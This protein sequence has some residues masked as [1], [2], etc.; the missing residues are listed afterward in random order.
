MGLDFRM[1]DF[2]YPLALLRMK[3]Q[4]ERNQYQPLPALQ[5]YQRSRMRKVLSHAYENV[6]YYRKLFDASALHPSEMGSLADCTRIPFLSKGVLSG[7]FAELTARNARVYKPMELRTSGTTGGQVKF[8]VDRSSNILEFVYYWRFW[9]WHGYRIGDRFAEFSAQSFTPIERNAA[10]Y[11]EFRRLI[12]RLLVNSLLLSKTNIRTY[13][14]LFSR[15][16]PSFLKGLPSNLYAFALLCSGLRKH[17]IS[18]RAIF[19]QGENLFPHQRKLIEQVFASPV[20]DSYGHLERTV[21]IS[22]CPSG[23]YHIHADYGF[24]ELVEPQRDLRLPLALAPGQSVFE[25]ASTSLY[26]LSMPLIRYKTGDLV[27]T[28]SAQSRCACGRSFPVVHSI[29]GRD[30]DIV[31]TPEGKAITA[32]YVALDRLPGIACG[33]IVQE[34]LDT[35]V[36]RMVSKPDAGAGLHDAVVETVHS[37]TG[38]AM[39]VVVRDCEL[40][41]M[42]PTDGTK[43]K[44]IVSHV[45]PSSLLQG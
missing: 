13:V 14:E 25:V 20:Y 35:V 17:G 1:R 10:R 29:V 32:L 11:C 21:A 7:S 15:F 2:A 34:S 42:Y 45:D 30:S 40:D 22:Q 33:Q 18:F 26:N 36:V 5:E 43:F 44:S 23:R 38:P 4:F 28:D 37:F 41:E 39:K 8:L 27:V 16:R 24:T 6:P 31:V 9:G 3:R 12:N 19:S